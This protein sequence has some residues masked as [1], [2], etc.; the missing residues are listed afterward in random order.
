MEVVEP[1]L[2]RARAAVAREVVVDRTVASPCDV[3]FA[4]FTQR[5]HIEKWWGPRGFHTE[6]DA[7]D[8]REG[9]AL[10]FLMRSDAMAE[11]A[12]HGVVQEL[13]PDERLV[14]TAAR[15]PFAGEAQEPEMLVAITFEATPAGNTDVTVTQRYVESERTRGLEEGW[16]EAFDRL[17][18]YLADGVVRS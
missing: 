15:E 2:V 13:I 12:W 18:E 17:E 3:V 14:F 7:L 5:E 6:V 8:L 10:R 9:G 11:E 4:A 1:S 16:L